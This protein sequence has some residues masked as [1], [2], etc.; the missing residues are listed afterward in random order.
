MK[1][2][3]KMVVCDCCGKVACVTEMY[4]VAENEYYCSDECAYKHGW[5]CCNHCYK[6]I[7]NYE[8]INIRGEH[9]CDIECC[10]AE[11]YEF[12]DKCCTFQMDVTINEYGEGICH[13][14]VTKK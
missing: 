6:W 9:Y 14:C 7:P 10:Y 2:L 11:G 3:N 4:E 8:A 12:C 5:R 1:D 13:K